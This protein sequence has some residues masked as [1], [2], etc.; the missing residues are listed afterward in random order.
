M[1]SFRDRFGAHWLQ[2]RRHLEVQGQALSITPSGSPTAESLSSSAGT[3]E[4][5]KSTEQGL[6]EKTSVPEG[7]DWELPQAGIAADS[8]K[9]VMETDG[10]A[11]REERDQDD[12]LEGKR[13]N[14]WGHHASISVDILGPA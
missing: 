4:Q 1:D 13:R 8:F 12:K 11:A 6:E 3:S 2:Y 10:P 5:N 14:S 9:A 7:E